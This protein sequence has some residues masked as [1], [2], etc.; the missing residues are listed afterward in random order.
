VGRSVALA[1]FALMVL[2]HVHGHHLYLRRLDTGHTLLQPKS[3][4]DAPSP[5]PL[6]SRVVIVVV[7]GL[8]DDVGE[9]VPELRALRGAR[10]IIRSE[11]P[12]YTFPNLT[13]MT[14]GVPPIYSGVR[15]NSGRARVALDTLSDAVV[16]SGR[17]VN[18]SDG[19]WDSF[20]A[21]VAPGT[22]ISPQGELQ[23]IYFGEVD[24][25]GHRHGAA[26]TEY[27]LAA[28]RAGALV[29]HVAAQMDLSRETLIVL[30]DH[31]HRARG[32]HGGQEPEVTGAYF[33]A[34]G[35]AIRRDIRLPDARMRDLAP[36]V[37]RLLG[38]PPPRDSMGAA[39][40][41]LFSPSPP[42]PP[43][44]D[45]YPRVLAARRWVRLG[46]ATPLLILFLFFT[47]R[48]F[49]ARDFLPAAIYIALFLVGYFALGYPLGW[50]IPR[51]FRMFLVETGLLG[52][53]A[54]AAAVWV[55]R[56]IGARGQSL[57][58]LWLCAIYL[59]IAAAAGL[60]MAWLER[61]AIAWAVILSATMLFW[62]GG[63]LGLSALYRS[64]V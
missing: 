29:A 21:R 63:A 62:L 45:E 64:K 25:A 42:P 26:S 9:E 50:S 47:R 61:P 36:T 17:R 20:G 60:D 48:H 49:R 11:W 1:G 18:I 13:A 44:E 39:M 27:S 28:S 35:A 54:G 57:T 15:T 2:T 46:I 19:G 22:A 51:G 24:M 59:F 3:A 23:W 58:A 53:A 12:S 6:A 41:D 56:R 10:R 38:T 43:D 4:A 34:T 52:M 55:G 5:P 7:D 8:R 32:G 30:A 37:A 33:L 31:G 40:L 16:R 14:T